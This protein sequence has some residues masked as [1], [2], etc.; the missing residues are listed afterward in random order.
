V[1]L[2]ITMS[3]DGFISGPQD[4]VKPLHNWLFSGDTPSAYNKFFE[5]SKKSARLFDKFIKNTGA[6]VAGR[7]TYDIADGWGGSHP[8]PNVPLFVLTSHVPNEVPKGSTPFTFVTDGIESAINQARR[9]AGKK[10][11]YVLGGASIAQQ[12]LSASLLD[13]MT[14]HLVPTVL[15]EGIP[16]FDK[17]NKQINLEQ[18]KMTEAPGITHLQFRVER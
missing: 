2:D 13:E 3:L 18:V 11:V 15:S 14:I 1:V 7:R 12:C 10:N 5:L 8:I 4:N 9:A 16:L 17:L 6:I